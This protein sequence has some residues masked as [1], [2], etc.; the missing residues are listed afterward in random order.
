MSDIN[1][2]YFTLAY[3]GLCPRCQRVLDVDYTDTWSKPQDRVCKR[4]CYH[5]Y[6]KWLIKA[7]LKDLWKGIKGWWHT[8]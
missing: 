3:F 2:N 7:A 1:Y 5:D 8:R 4:C 6:W